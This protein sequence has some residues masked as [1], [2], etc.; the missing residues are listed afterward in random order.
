MG[1][2]VLTRKV[3]GFTLPVYR[4]SK[5]SLAGNSN[6]VRS[7]VLLQAWINLSDMWLGLGLGLGLLDSRSVT[8]LDQLVRHVVAKEPSSICHKRRAGVGRVL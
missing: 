3:C 7:K 4:K 5:E 2:H 8:R 1:A 6:P